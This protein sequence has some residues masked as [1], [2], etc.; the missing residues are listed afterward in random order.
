MV[1]KA[2]MGTNLSKWT[3]PVLPLGRHVERPTRAQLVAELHVG[4]VEDSVL[5]TGAVLPGAGTEVL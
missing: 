5:R 2:N 1:A 3:S 4:G